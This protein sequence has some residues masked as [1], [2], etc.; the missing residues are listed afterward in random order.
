[1]NSKLKQHL[2]VA[3]AY[4]MAIV[5]SF[6]LGNILLLPICNSITG[7]ETKGVALTQTLMR[8]LWPAIAFI[9]IFI[10]KKNGSEEKITFVAKLREEPYD[11]KKD[12]IKLMKSKDFWA[13]LIFVSVITFVYWIFN[14]VFSW[15]FFNIPLYFVFNLCVNLYLHRTWAKNTHIH[16][17]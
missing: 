6:L 9:I 11:F 5:A 10:Y 8:L 4:V 13:E 17:D 16:Y 7:S 15:I 2:F 3:L 1:M 14:Y 12:F